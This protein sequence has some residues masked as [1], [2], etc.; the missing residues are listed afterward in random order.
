[1]NFKCEISPDI[2]NDEVVIRC[3]NKTH[4]I[5]VLENIIKNYLDQEQELTL[6][7]QNTEYYIPKR[8]ILYF[9]TEDGK[10]KAHTTDR[11]F[12]TEYK[13]FELEQIMPACFIRV[14][15]SCVLNTAKVEAITRNLAGASDVFFKDCQKKVCV[16]R[17][18]YKQ[19]KE[20][21]QEMRF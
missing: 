10:I 12:T 14:S 15:K 20:K 7:I 4:K 21:I 9:E 2:E 18:Y 11:I 8:D 5:C 3:R 13:L 16:S 1:M 19:L 17:S 6:Y